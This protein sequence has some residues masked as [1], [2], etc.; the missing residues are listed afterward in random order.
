MNP[1]IWRC[2]ASLC[3]VVCAAGALGS[4]CSKP[5]SEGTA[6]PAPA[7][8]TPAAAAAPAIPRNPLKEAYFGEQHIHTAYSLDA[9]LGGTRLTPFEAYEFA[10]GAEVEVNG[11]KHKLDRPLD[12]VAITDHAEYIGEMY[13][14]F[15]AG[16]PGHD[17][18]S[19]QTLRGMTDLKERQGWFMKYVAGNN[20]G[21]NPKHPE[22]YMGPETTASAWKNIEVAAAEKYNQPGKFTAF[23]AFEWTS[24]PGGAN[25]HRN[26]IFRDN[27]VPDLPMSA[28]ELPREEGLWNWMAELEGQGMK[29]LAIPHNSNASKTIMFGSSA[30]SDGKPYDKAYLDRRAHFEPVIEIMQ[31]KGNSEVHRKFWQADEF[32]NFENADSMGKFSGRVP[33]QRNF[34][35]WGVIEGLAWEQKLGTNPFK[36]GFVGGTDNHNGLPSEVMEAGSYGKGWNGAHGAE[37]GSVDRLKTGDVGGWI[38]V[39]DENPGALTGIWAESNTRG[40]LWDALKA[41]E[42]F[43]TSGPRIKVRFFAGAGLPTAIDARSLVETGYAKGVPMGGTLSGLH[44]APVFNAYAMKDPDGANLDRLQIVKGWVD[45]TGA[46][47][48]K[49]YNVA[50][51]GERKLRADGELPAVGNTVDL[52]TAAYKNSI[53]SPELMASWIDPDF[54][55]A[56]YALYYVRALEI[57][58]P[59]WTT[60]KTV[61][62]NLPLLADVAATIQ[63]RAWTSPIWYTPARSTTQ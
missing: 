36:L 23:I 25:L 61:A 2:R 18:E 24:A 63:E 4:G 37:D 34:V 56:R 11:V 50:W 53:G 16:A 49:I 30:D 3:L 47:H 57:P 60:Y 38:D 26:V 31:V 33:D 28:Y 45:A 35:R 9:Y 54:D 51:S 22:F 62:N 27:H 6:P 10:Q 19:L 44:A 1:R 20:R 43:A 8:A 59:R 48:E 29:P 41:R 46:H 58:T 15:T 42:T 40:A 39:K 12:W 14:T 13:S 32:A 17:Q 7:A 55:P 21:A 5:S 52:K